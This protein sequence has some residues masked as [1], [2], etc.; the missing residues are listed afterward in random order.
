[1]NMRPIFVVLFFETD[2]V[3]FY[4]LN[5]VLCTIPDVVISRFHKYHCIIMHVSVQYDTRSFTCFAH[6]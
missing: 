6:Q 3:S 1:M 2:L 4:G 5:N